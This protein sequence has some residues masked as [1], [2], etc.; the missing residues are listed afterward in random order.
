MTHTQS[1]AETTAY[2]Q[3]LSIAEIKAMFANGRRVQI[4]WA[5]DMS[6]DEDDFIKSPPN[7]LSIKTYAMPETELSQL[8]ED[9]EPIQVHLTKETRGNSEKIQA[10]MD[11]TD[12]DYESVEKI[13]FEPKRAALGDIAIYCKGLNIDFLKFIGKALA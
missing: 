7:G 13:L 3:S 8:L 4:N 12:L 6:D 5:E 10:I 2:I 1:R 11:L 9:A